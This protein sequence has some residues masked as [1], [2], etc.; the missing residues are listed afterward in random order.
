MKFKDLGIIDPILK[1]LND[2][3]YE[4]PTEIQEK[5]IPHI[6][7]GKDVLGSAQTGTGKTAAF[8]IP[9][10]QYLHKHNGG[11]HLKALIVTPTR[12][13]A[14]Q[15]DENIKEYSKYT[16]LSHAV[17]FGGVGQEQQVRKLKKGV[18]IITATP[19]R[20]LDLMNQ[21]YIDLGRIE[22]FV[23]D[24]A[25]R[26]L[27]MGFIHDIK[28]LLAKLPQ[29][30][31]S[32]FFSATLPKS[33]ITLSHN[34]LNN[35][36]QVKVAAVSSTAETVKQYV[37]YTN[38][39]A[40]RQLLEHILKDEQ[41]DQVLLFE[42]TKHGSNRVAKQLSKAGI[43]AKAIHGDKSQSQRQNALNA[44]KEGK[45]RVLVATDIV[46][47]GID[48]DKLKYVINYNIPNEPESYVHRIGRSG[49]AG[50]DGIAISISEPEENAFVKDIE[51]LINQRI[52]V[53]RDHPFPQTEKPMTEAEKKQWYKEKQRKRQEFF[54]NRKKKKSHGSGK[55][56]HKRHRR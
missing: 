55:K 1:A 45:T 16:Q 11:Q 46:A 42:R 26:M 48:I 21:G 17:I 29:K 56:H 44:F 31:Q 6:L 3:G 53:V 39:D 10:I 52:E 33:I 13:L 36:I 22:L 27:D 35:P 40:K 43:S 15:I 28:K 41:I 5:A 9:I 32:L 37:Y 19:G 12:E 4:T 50:E 49:R 30:R 24:E 8:A 47:R 2:K 51:K 23:L 54:A 38:R 34:I 20:L 25:D 14:L 18:D 7:S